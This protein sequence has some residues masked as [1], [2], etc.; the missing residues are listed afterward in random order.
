MMLFQ[1]SGRGEAEDNARPIFSPDC[2]SLLL[3]LLNGVSFLS[4]FFWNVAKKA[5]MYDRKPRHAEIKF[6]QFK[7]QSLGK[8]GSKYSQDLQWS[9]DYY[10]PLVHMPYANGV[11]L[12]QDFI[13]SLELWSLNR[14]EMDLSNEVLNIDLIKG[15]QRYQRSKLE[16]EKISANQPGSSP[17]PKLFHDL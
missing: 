8:Q 4:E 14:Y 2:K 10:T 16:F 11:T 7:L 3:G 15:L 13:K 9:L 5:K 17:S 12:S 1:L 6:P